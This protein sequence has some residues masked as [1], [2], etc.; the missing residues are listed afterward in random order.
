MCAP[1][2]VHDESRGG[3][4]DCENHEAGILAEADVHV[5]EEFRTLQEHVADVV[6][7]H[8]QHTKLHVVRVVHRR[9]GCKRQ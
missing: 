5:H 6:Q 7:Y 1:A 8:D 2:D 3:E 4:S 9:S